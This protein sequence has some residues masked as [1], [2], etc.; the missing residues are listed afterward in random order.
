MWQGAINDGADWISLVIWNDY[1]EDSNLMPYHWPPD[2]ENHYNRDGS[3][4]DA[5]AY[6]SRW[7]KTGRPP[8]ITQDKLVF[9]YR[10]RIEVAAPGMG[11][12]AVGDLSSRQ[13]SAS[14]RST[15]T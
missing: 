11:W 3:Y 6:A 13:V 8:L 5:T 12:P 4:L 9:T 1:N 10:D 2:S 14:I 15:T 7:F